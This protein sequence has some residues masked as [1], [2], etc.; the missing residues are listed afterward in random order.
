M[1]LPG[2][3]SV[4]SGGESTQTCVCKPLSHWTPLIKSK[5]SFIWETVHGGG[6]LEGTEWPD[7]PPATQS[8]L[9]SQETMAGA[10]F[11]HF[12]NCVNGC[13]TSGCDAQP[14]CEGRASLWTQIFDQSKPL[15]QLR[16]QAQPSLGHGLASHLL[17][18]SASRML[19]AHPVL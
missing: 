4:G 18:L 11:G 10:F 3:W 17:T 9:P 19:S 15:T 7:S 1:A 13:R 6:D 5:N 12:T 14:V 8:L 16:L 2:P